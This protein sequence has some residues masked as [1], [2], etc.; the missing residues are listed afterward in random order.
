MCGRFIQI[1]N[2][3]KIKVS[4][5]DLE[6]G[7]DISPAFRPRYNI[8]PTQDILAVL[9]HQVPTLAYTRWGL[10]PFWAKDLSIGSRMINARC[11][12]LLEKASFRNPF[13]KSR[14][15]IFTDGFFEWKT[16]DKSK[17]PYFIHMKDSSPF[18]LAGLWERWTDRATG[19]TIVSSSIITTSPNGLIMDI[20]NRMP[21]ILAPDDYRTWLS[22]EG[23]PDNVLMACLKT[24]PP[25]EME[26]YEI[27]R[28]VNS[29]ANDSPEIIKPYAP[30]TDRLF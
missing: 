26:A 27:S 25:E 19:N 22:M 28:M 10:V 6:M 7:P 4:I 14:C 5:Q 20:H 21:V 1:S 18:A 16:T 29:P 8:A 9:N 13:R 2:P 30:G 17:A 23:Q 12:T 11:E 3:E 15:V 24:Y